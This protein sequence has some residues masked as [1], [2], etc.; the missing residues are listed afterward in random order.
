MLQD[1]DDV[2]I[3][4]VVIVTE[5]LSVHHSLIKFGEIDIVDSYFDAFADEFWKIWEKD[6][7]LV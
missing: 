7:W 3:A 5:E 4:R 2:T 6:K 1:T